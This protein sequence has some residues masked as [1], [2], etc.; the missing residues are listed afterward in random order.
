MKHSRRV[1]FRVY[2]TSRHWENFGGTDVCTVEQIPK[3]L[4]VEAEAGIKVVE[5]GTIAE[6]MEYLIR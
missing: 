4:K 3:K 6:A 2:E 5:V 1:D